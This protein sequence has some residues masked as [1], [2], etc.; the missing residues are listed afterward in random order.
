M[1]RVG[2]S[3]CSD[4]GYGPLTFSDCVWTLSLVTGPFLRAA[5]A[6][7]WEIF[8]DTHLSGIPL[9]TSGVLGIQHPTAIDIRPDYSELYSQGCL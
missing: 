8:I 3:Y 4:S 9:L 2:D 7:S 1:R 5:G 6:W